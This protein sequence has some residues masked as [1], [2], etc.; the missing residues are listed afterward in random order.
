[1]SKL[2]LP[3]NNRNGIKIWCRKCRQNNTGCNHYDYQNYR[4]NYIDP[5]TGKHKSKILVATQ[6]EDAVI[7]SINF[8]KGLKQ[9]IHTPASIIGNDYTLADGIVKYRMY[10]N[11][12]TE[13]QQYN[14][15]LTPKYIKETIGFLVQFHDSV[16]ENRKIEWIKPPQINRADV[17]YFFGKIKEKHY[18]KSV[19]NIIQ[20]L[21]TFF[22]FLIDKED[23]IMKNYF[24][25]CASLPVPKKTIKT[26]D[27]EDFEAILNAVDTYHPILVQNNG[28]KI[29]LYQT[30]MKDAFRLFLLAGGR[31]EEIIHLRWNDIYTLKN[32]TKFFM[33]GNLKANRIQKTD[34]EYIK[35]IPIGADLEIALMDMGMEQKKHTTERI[36]DPTEKYTK[37]TMM[38]MITKAFSHFKKGAGIKSEITLKHLRKTY[39]TWTNQVLGKDTG[40]ITSH[41]GSKILNDHYLDPTILSAVE[42]AALDVRIFG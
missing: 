25:E 12:D 24:K 33:I 2:K 37:N 14:K 23:I 34:K 4:A 7:E 28:N 42:K 1:M 35:Y 36:I 26:I 41:A 29:N 8:K 15:N 40:K 16:R 17:S 30:W 3:K 21:T 32:G 18:P 20:S 6:Y 22:N 10:L 31:R 11:G 13:Y 5:I 39:I 19:N 38:E 27:K 9:Q